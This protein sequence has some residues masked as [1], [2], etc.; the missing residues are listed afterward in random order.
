MWNLMGDTEALET[1]LDS[2]PDVLAH[3]I[4]T[5]P[6]LYRRVRPKA[7]Y[8]RSLNILKA[9]A[10]L[11]NDVV[12]KSGLMVGLGETHD[13]I[14]EV[15]KDAADHG[16]QILTAGQYLRP[17]DW[18]LPV[19]KYYTPEEFRII[20]EKGE[21]AGLKYIESGPLVRSSYMAHKQMAYYK[22]KIAG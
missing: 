15:I 11:R 6:R 22:R 14:L 7:R 13:E 21:A 19:E 2:S 16:C 4:E 5:V 20:K 8:E 10:D 12:V 1:I 18:H 17:T 3:N 9:T